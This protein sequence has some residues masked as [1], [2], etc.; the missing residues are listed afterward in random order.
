MKQNYITHRASTLPYVHT[1]LADVTP[2]LALPCQSNDI[3]TSTAVDLT[4]RELHKPPR[5]AVGKIKP[6]LLRPACAAAC[7]TVRR[8]PQTPENFYIASSEMH[9]DRT[10]VLRTRKMNLNVETRL[11]LPP[12]SS[13]P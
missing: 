10:P 9:R 3:H 12:T 1:R 7:S 13:R 6:W 11:Y 4:R 2:P 8:F 5:N